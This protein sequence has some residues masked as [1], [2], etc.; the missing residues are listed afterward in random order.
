MAYDFGSRQTRLEMRYRKDALF[1]RGLKIRR[2]V[3]GAANV[4]RRLANANEYTWGFEEIAPALPL[5]ALAVSPR[6]VSLISFR[7]ARA[8]NC[9]VIGL[10]AKQR[11][12]FS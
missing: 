4:D 9:A 1:R 3:L 11:S 6:R 10:I 7:Q 2:E 5:R 8:R 12:D